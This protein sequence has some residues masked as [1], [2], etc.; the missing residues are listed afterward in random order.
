MS[1]K[2]PMHVIFAAV[3]VGGRIGVAA[4]TASNAD[5]PGYSSVSTPHA[6]SDVKVR[7]STAPL[8][9]LPDRGHR[10]WSSASTHYCSCHSGGGGRAAAGIGGSRRCLTVGP[11]GSGES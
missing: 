2:Q 6:S 3:L 10:S 11:A 5:S 9:L 7:T 8:R 4:A 1:P